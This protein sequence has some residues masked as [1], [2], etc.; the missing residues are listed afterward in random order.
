MENFTKKISVDLTPK[1]KEEKEEKVSKPKEIKKRVIT[2]TDKW[3]FS[4]EDLDLTRQY[5][6]IKEIHCN[7]I[8]NKEECNVIIQ[9]INQKIS[10][11]RNQD[12][13]KSLL[14]EN[15]VKFDNVI[16]LMI[17]CENQCFYC[18]KLVHVL[19]ENVRE[20]QQWTLDRMDN[21]YGHNHDNV[22]IACLNCNLRRRTMYHERYVFT[23]QLQ[24][25]K[26]T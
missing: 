26:K 9:H 17:K 10:G 12:V 7:N 4:N 5:G 16:D 2:S 15:L 1:K 21:N 23:K 24:I 14:S 3:T 20:P 22:E 18:K 25:V 13:I 11:Y 19:Y 6:Y 8:I